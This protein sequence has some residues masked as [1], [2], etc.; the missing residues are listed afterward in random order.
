MRRMLSDKQ[1]QEFKNKQDKLTAGTNITINENNVI[2]ATGEISGTVAW[3]DV[4]GKPTFATVAT[5]GSYNDLSNKPT[6]TNV[7]GTSTDG[8]NWDSITIGSTTRNIPAGGGGGSSN[9]DTVVCS[10]AANTP[11]GVVW[12]QDIPGSSTTITGT[13]AASASTFGKFYFV[14]ESSR[15]RVYTTVKVYSEGAGEYVYNWQIME[16]TQASDDVFVAV[17][18]TTTL[19]ELNTAHTA[20]KLLVANVSNIADAYATCI[21]AASNSYTFVRIDWYS[22]STPSIYLYEW[23]TTY[24]TGHQ[25]AGGG[26]LP[27]LSNVPT[28]NGQYCLSYSTLL[29]NFTPAS[30]DPVN[31]VNYTTAIAANDDVTLTDVELTNNCNLVTFVVQ[32]GAGIKCSA[33]FPRVEV[34][35]SQAMVVMCPDGYVTLIFDHAE[36][37]LTITNNT[38]STLNAVEV[39][40]KY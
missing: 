6:I 14:E 38:S 9:F 34:G 25:A 22:G 17:M 32:I 33:T 12:T 28:N 3:D 8:V 23:T 27:I 5:S 1:V 11:N 19:S 10:E 40:T 35:A 31:V 30:I 7:S 20:G 4:T 39:Y 29:K 37:E 15:T 16:D 21:Y 26:K 13:L 2:S 18:S 36:D 24:A